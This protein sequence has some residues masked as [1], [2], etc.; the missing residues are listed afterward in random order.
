[1]ILYTFLQEVLE[2]EVIKG[3]ER[4]PMVKKKK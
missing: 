2:R 4:E 3:R 1:M